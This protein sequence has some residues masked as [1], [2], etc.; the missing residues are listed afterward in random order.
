MD[1]SESRGAM[2]M[3][4]SRGGQATSRVLDA[5]SSEA[6]VL[7]FILELRYN[8]GIRRLNYE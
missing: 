6:R 8:I 2:Q 1:V 4:T 7:L 5:W 3:R